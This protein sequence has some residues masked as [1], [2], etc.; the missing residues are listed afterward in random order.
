MLIG[1]ISSRPKHYLVGSHLAH[2][3]LA[4]HHRHIQ[5]DASFYSIK[6]LLLYHSTTA[7]GLNYSISDVSASIWH[8]ILPAGNSRGKYN[9]RPV[10]AGSWTLLGMFVLRNG[11][12]GLIHLGFYSVYLLASLRRL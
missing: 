4:A 3:A 12:I 9:L 8:V 10:G 6:L 7:T 5:S 1:V 11:F 2:Y